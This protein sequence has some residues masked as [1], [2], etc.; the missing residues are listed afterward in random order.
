MKELRETAHR[1]PPKR[2]KLGKAS[3]AQEEN[4]QSG[5]SAKNN[6]PKGL[7]RAGF[8]Q[9]ASSSTSAAPA[10]LFGLHYEPRLPA[11]AGVG[12]PPPGKKKRIKRRQ[13]MC[14]VFDSEASTKTTSSLNPQVSPR[15]MRLVQIMKSERRRKRLSMIPSLRMIRTRMAMKRPPTTSRICVSRSCVRCPQDSGLGN[16]ACS[17]S[18][19]GIDK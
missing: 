14:I 3:R 9:H 10:L 8:D 2:N 7:K 19:E 1:F 6:S 4:P 15:F 18:S 17:L 12:L 13:S 11:F 5:T 16:L